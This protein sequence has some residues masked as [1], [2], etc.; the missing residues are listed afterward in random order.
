MAQHASRL[1]LARTRH[2]RQRQSCLRHRYT[3][4]S[5]ILRGHSTPKN[6]HH[7]F[8]LQFR[9]SNLFI[10]AFPFSS[11]YVFAK[12]RFRPLLRVSLASLPYRSI[13]RNADAFQGSSEEV[14]PICIVHIPVLPPYDPRTISNLPT[15]SLCWSMKMWMTRPPNP[16]TLL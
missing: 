10:L 8:S 7:H 13:D 1:G 2:L 11:A 5:A 12:T 4:A 15:K 3:A 9:R 16:S 14:D 6:R